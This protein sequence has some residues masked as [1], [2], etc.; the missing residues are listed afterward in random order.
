MIDE[1][2]VVRVILAVLKDP[3]SEYDR[4]VLADA[5]EEWADG[6]VNRLV[7]LGATVEG[8]TVTDA[9]RR[10]ESLRGDGTWQ[11]WACMDGKR[12]LCWLPHGHGQMIYVA[13]T[14]QWP[15]CNRCKA[16]VLNMLMSNK[17]NDW[18]WTCQPCFYA[19]ARDKH[20]AVVAVPAKPPRVR[21][22]RGRFA[23]EA[24]GAI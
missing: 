8:A 1:A 23:K 16:K 5:L 6:D 4:M 3:G 21:D 9:C 12:Q 22:K 20:A 18:A 11:L 7:K 14:D 15:G 19:H 13:L 24:A 17:D 2:T 10:L